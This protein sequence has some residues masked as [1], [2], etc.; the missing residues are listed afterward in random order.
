ML[1]VHSGW[2]I[3]ANSVHTFI[4]LSRSRIFCFSNTI[5]FNMMVE[6]EILTPRDTAFKEHLFD[7]LSVELRNLWFL[8][9]S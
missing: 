9:P 1:V 5:K 2:I 8:N 3:H 4:L 7:L 6:R